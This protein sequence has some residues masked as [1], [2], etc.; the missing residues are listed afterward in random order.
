MPLTED[1][2][3]NTGIKK[4]SAA[5]RAAPVVTVKFGAVSIITKSNF[6]KALEFRNSETQVV[7]LA[8]LLVMSQDLTFFH[9]PELYINFS[10]L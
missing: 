7:D 9:C 4:P 10:T 6:F 3:G 1:F 5:A 2:S 8:H